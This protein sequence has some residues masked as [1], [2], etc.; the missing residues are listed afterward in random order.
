[1]KTLPDALGVSELSKP[2]GMS[3]FARI[4]QS[5]AKAVGLEMRPTELLIFGDLRAG[6]VLMNEYPSLAIDSPLKVLVREDVENRVWVS[7]NSPAFYKER[8][9]PREEPFQAIGGLID[10]PLE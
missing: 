7:Y 9:H 6:T 5:A 4:N 3:I 2:K 8:H 1:M 10:T